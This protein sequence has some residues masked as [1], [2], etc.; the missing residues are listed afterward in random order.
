MP[1]AKLN[2]ICKTVHLEV[3]EHLVFCSFLCTLGLVCGSDW[4]LVG[5][6]GLEEGEEK[7]YGG[8]SGRDVFCCADEAVAAVADG[9]VGIHL[10][11]HSV[12]AVAHGAVGLYLSYHRILPVAHGAV[13]VDLASHTVVSVLDCPVFAESPY[14]HVRLVAHGAVVLYL[15]DE[16][17]AAVAHLLGDAAEDG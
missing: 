7:E 5:R 9:A 10:S 6:V 16:A 13:G 1:Y 11:D 3:E 4:G 15:T 17:V 2:I 8:S 14:H 12:M